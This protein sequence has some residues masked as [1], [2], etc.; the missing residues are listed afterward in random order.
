MSKERNTMHFFNNILHDIKK[1]QNATLKKG[2]NQ[3]FLQMLEEYIIKSEAP[4]EENEM[5]YL[6]LGEPSKHVK[7]LLALV[8]QM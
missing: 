2:N 1:S 6:L 8:G 4:L 7:G 5:L 3:S